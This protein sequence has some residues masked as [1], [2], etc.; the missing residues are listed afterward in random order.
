MRLRE[1]VRWGVKSVGGLAA[2]LALLTLW[3]DGLGVPP[4][5]AIVPNFV[6]IS[7]VGYLVT[8]RWVFRDEAS[9]SGVRGHAKRYLSMQSVMLGGKAANYVIYVLLIAASMDYRV[10]WAL[11]AIVTF[12]GTFTGNKLLWSS[13]SPTP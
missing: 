13:D 1:L 11:G 5:L 2:N 3:V 6:I 7:A 12:L 10:A 4:Q 8:D 9:A